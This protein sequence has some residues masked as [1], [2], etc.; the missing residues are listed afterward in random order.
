MIRFAGLQERL[1][2]EDLS[3][4]HRE[5][6]AGFFGPPIGASVF[7]GTASSEGNST[8]ALEPGGPVRPRPT[9]RCRAVAAETAQGFG[10]PVAKRQEMCWRLPRVRRVPGN[11]H[12]LHVGRAE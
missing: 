4:K 8:S 11:K 5:I 9:G 6:F 3:E 10:A 12:D 7:L 2:V 1:R